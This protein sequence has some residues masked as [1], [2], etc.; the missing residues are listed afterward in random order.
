MQSEFACHIGSKGN[1][2]CRMCMVSNSTSMGGTSTPSGPP[3]DPLDDTDTDPLTGQSSILPPA[4]ESDPES[5]SESIA[6][7]NSA[8]AV[9]SAKL[10]SMQGMIDRITQFFLVCL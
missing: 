2:F 6:S 1:L 5:G 10:E 8:T 9:K 7:A 3:D 4:E